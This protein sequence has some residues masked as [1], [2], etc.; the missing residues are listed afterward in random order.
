MLSFG[1]YFSVF[2]FCLAFLVCFYNLGEI[3]T[4]PA[5]EGKVLSGSVPMLTMCAHWLWQEDW[6]QNKHGKGLF[7][8]FSALAGWAGAC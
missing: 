6:N 8:G 7:S 5:V 3:I 2:S 1:T 4:S